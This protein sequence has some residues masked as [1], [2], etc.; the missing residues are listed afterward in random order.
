MI[1]ESVTP[2]GYYIVLPGIYATREAAEAAIRQERS[3]ERMRA[4][5]YKAG[6]YGP[7]RA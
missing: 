2:Q 5:L 1:E 3:N 4:V 6:W 7:E